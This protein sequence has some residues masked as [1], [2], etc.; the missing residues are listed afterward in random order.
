[1]DEIN[2]P[3]NMRGRLSKSTALSSDQQRRLFVI[4][5]EEIS[6]VDN[7]MFHDPKAFTALFKEG[8]SIAEPDLTWYH[9]F[10]MS[11]LGFADRQVPGETIPLT[12]EM[13]RTLFL[14]FH[15]SCQKL[16][17]LKKQAEQLP[18]ISDG[19]AHE[20]LEWDK[21]R[22]DRCDL[23]VKYF[24]KLVLALVRKRIWPNTISLGDAVGECNKEL[25]EAIKNYDVQRRRRSGQPTNFTTFAKTVINHCIDGLLRDYYK[26]S[27]RIKQFSVDGNG[28]PIDAE[29]TT[30]DFPHSLS[31]LDEQVLVEMRSGK[32]DEKGMVPNEAMRVDKKLAY[33]LGRYRIWITAAEGKSPR[34]SEA[35]VHQD[36]RADEIGRPLPIPKE[37]GFCWARRKAWALCLSK[38]CT[39]GKR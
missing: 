34:G 39:K 20:M 27:G 28:Q 38:L 29:D 7:S 5:G 6:F 24:L 9:N 13:E 32:G 1:M 36:T 14:Q 4:F 22:Q 3:E 30:T 25:I 8:P 16:A 19:L 2:E 26:K 37:L 12:E 10:M 18:T 23:I 11:E 21:V 33:S 17:M 15:G 31:E 35:D